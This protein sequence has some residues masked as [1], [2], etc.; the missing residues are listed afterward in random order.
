MEGVYDNDFRRQ[1][2]PLA[3]KSLPKRRITAL[4]SMACHVALSYLEMWTVEWW[5]RF[6]NGNDGAQTKLE[7][8][9]SN[10]FAVAQDH[11]HKLQ[12]AMEEYKQWIS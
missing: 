7:R 2:S 6:V 11:L 3:R 4:N 5:Q 1:A 12:L 9:E 10:E 8:G